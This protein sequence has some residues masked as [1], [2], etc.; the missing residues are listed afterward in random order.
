MLKSYC[1]SC[2]GQGVLCHTTSPHGLI[3]PPIKRS[4]TLVSCVVVTV[5]SVKFTVNTVISVAAKREDA[6]LV[7]GYG[8]I[9]PGNS[10][11]PTSSDWQ[12]VAANNYYF[13]LFTSG[14]SLKLF[15][16]LLGTTN[17]FDS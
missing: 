3:L 9:L 13:R 7:A 4:R 15:C 11:I 12:K 8:R 17:C 14:F 6:K 2:G 10:Y 16:A 5:I 1:H